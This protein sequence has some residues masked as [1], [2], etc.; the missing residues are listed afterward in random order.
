MRRLWLSLLLVP[1][2]VAAVASA[3]WASP[4]APAARSAPAARTAPPRPRRP[5]PAARHEGLQGQ[6]AAA[7]AGRAEVLPGL[8]R[9]QFR[10]QHPRGRVGVLRGAGADAAQLR[11]LRDEAGAG[12]PAGA[13]EAGQPRRR[14][15]DRDQPVPRGPRPLPQQQGPADQPRVE[16]RA[17]L[18]LQ[19]R[20]RLRVRGHPDRKL[21]HQSCSCAA[22]CTCRWARCSTRCSSS[23]PRSRSTAI[24]TCHWPR[25]RTAASGSRWT[26]R[27]SSTSW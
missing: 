10:H 16:R 13:E 24:P 21:P 9:R 18:L 5:G 27:T 25:S 19:P 11:E 4:A 26:S 14:Q 17:L 3:A 2:M 20:R 1:V 23:A 7:A 22:G 8:D 6:G 15:P 12:P